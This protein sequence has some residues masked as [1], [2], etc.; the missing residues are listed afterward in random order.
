MSTHSDTENSLIFNKNNFKKLG[1][2]SKRWVNVLESFPKN[3]PLYEKHLR[4]QNNLS[5]GGRIQTGVKIRENMNP[6]RFR[7]CFP[8][9]FM[10]QSG[11]QV[12]EADSNEQS[13]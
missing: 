7:P 4:N 10:I 8:G 2:D 6:G 11:Q 5:T 13:R 12:K 3:N 9:K 1:N